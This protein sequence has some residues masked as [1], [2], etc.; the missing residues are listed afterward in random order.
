MSDNDSN[1]VASRLNTALELR[2]MKPVELSAITGIG[3]SSISQY[4]SGQVKPKQDRIYLIAQALDVNELWLMGLSENI[5][6]ISHHEY[7]KMA[8]LEMVCPPLPD[9][10]AYLIN[11]YRSLNKVGQK[12]ILD[13]IIDLSGNDKYKSD[14]VAKN[15]ERIS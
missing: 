4:L 3:K 6:R 1:I 7:N 15:G 11:M 5:H 13:Y 9:D 10:E 12:K 8:I 2:R 14:L